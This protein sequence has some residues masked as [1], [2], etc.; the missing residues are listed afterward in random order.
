MNR[1]STQFDWHQVFNEIKSRG[2]FDSDAQLAESLGL[3]RAQISAWRTGRTTLGTLTRLK[4]LDALGHDSLRPALS[5]LYPDKDRED[6]IRR[7]ANLVER[8]WSG[9]RSH[10]EVE[11]FVASESAYDGGPW[12]GNVLLATLSESDRAKFIQNFTCLPLRSGQIIYD[13]N[14][15]ISDV[16]FPTTADV[17][18][19][20]IVD[21][22]AVDIVSVGREGLV[23]NGLLLDVA[24]W[25]ACA[26]V[27]GAGLAVK[28]DAKVLREILV[29]STTLRRSIFGYMQAL[30]GQ[31][32]KT[33]ID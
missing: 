18:I 32:T 9:A 20:L 10:S 3:S 8:V 11:T 4:L 1:H 23:G 17:S 30:W 19:V 7:Q 2:Q 22:R 31:L 16:Y 24:I 12:S 6:S 13:R 33:S 5:S 26:I 25:D 21:G 14:I 29:H 27:K 15:G 28:M